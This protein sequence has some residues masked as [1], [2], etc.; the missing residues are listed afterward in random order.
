[1]QT[2]SCGHLVCKVVGGAGWRSQWKPGNGM[3]SRESFGLLGAV[4]VSG[5]SSD[6]SKEWILEADSGSL[7][8]MLLWVR[9]LSSSFLHKFHEIMRI[10]SQV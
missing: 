9:S 5:H 8:C 10:V 4:H 6:C 3:L 2:H 7:E 1:M